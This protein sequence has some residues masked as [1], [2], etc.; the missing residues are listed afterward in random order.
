MVY[1]G[2]KNWL[3]RKIDEKAKLELLHNHQ[4]LKTILITSTRVVYDS[5]SV[6]ANMAAIV[7]H[8]G[9]RVALI[10]A[11]FKRPLLHELFNVPN[12]VGL[13][14]I[15]HGERS[16]QS[17]LHSVN[18]N[19]LFLLT[20]GINNNGKTDPFASQQMSKMLSQLSR[21]FDKV[22]IHGPPLIYTETASLAA[23]VDGVIVLIHPNRN[24]TDSTRVVMDKLQ[25]TGSRIIGVVMRDQPKY[26][27]NQ[28]AFIEKLLTYDRRAHL[29]T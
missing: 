10:D 17:L 28:S 16:L 23:K 6:A 11:D 25:K 26:Q 5:N 12:R 13:M 2:L 29:P 21:E 19:H 4:T 9:N 27:V 3:K 22:I 14:D 20:T 15:L 7:S 24:R 18:S 8:Q 1:S